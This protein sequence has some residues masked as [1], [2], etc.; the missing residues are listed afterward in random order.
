MHVWCWSVHVRCWR[1][2]SVELLWLPLRAAVAQLLPHTHTPS[3][4]LLLFSPL[5]MRVCVSARFVPLQGTLQDHDVLQDRLRRIL[6][7]MTFAEAY[8][9]SGGRPAGLPLIF[10]VSQ[11]RLRRCWVQA[12]Y[13]LGSSVQQQMAQLCLSL[14][15]SALPACLPACLPAGRILNVSVS[16]ADT[17]EPP[18]LL[19]YLTGGW[20]GW[21]WVE[22][23]GRLVGNRMRSWSAAAF[24]PSACSLPNP[25]TYSQ[26]LT[27]T[28]RLPAASCRH[29][30]QP[31]TCWCGARWP[32]APPSPS[33]TRPS[34]CWRGTAGARWCPSA[35]RRR[36]SCSGAGG[37]AAWR[38]T[39]P[40]EGSGGWADGQ[41]GPGVWRSGCTVSQ[42]S[43][44]YGPTG[45]PSSSHL[46]ILPP[47]YCPPC[48]APLCCSEMFNVNH[49]IVSQ[50]NPYVLPLIGEGPACLPAC[51]HTRRHAAP[52][53]RA[54][55][56]P[57]A[58]LPAC[59]YARSPAWSRPHPPAHCTRSPE[60]PGP[61]QAGQPG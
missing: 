2:G 4:P 1:R 53:S 33:S 50:A 8:Q 46:P 18:R 14:L 45:Q 13:P 7:E 11:W 6:G 38:K 31:P 26:I 43:P 9:R 30:P 25:C 51:L 41:W 52:G 42:L 48:T 29:L 32:A 37:T 17:S 39:C 16:A 58:W 35:P 24:P 47:L 22:K 61:P 23:N 49:F 56:L 34:S 44:P 55:L 10:L 27:R 59:A 12:A 21:G 60:A 57:P 36:G 3:S 19:N 20:T 15:P 5:H 54:M 28:H 40:C